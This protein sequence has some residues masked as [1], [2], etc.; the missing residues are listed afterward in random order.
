[1][2][3]ITKIFILGIISISSNLTAQ[4]EQT[5]IDLFVN[6]MLFLADGFASPASESAAYQAT[7]G[8]F[9]SAR[10][11]ETWKVDISVHANGIFVPSSK[12]EFTINNNDFNILQITGDDRAVIP[13][14]FGTETD[15]QFEG[16]VEY[17]GQTIPISGFDAIDGIDKGA[18]VYP[19]AQV[20]VGLPYGTEIGVRAL[21]AMEI[22]GSEFS[23]YGVGLKHNFSQYFRFNNEEDLQVAAV[24]A[25]N[26]FDVKYDF[27]PISVEQVVQLSQ[28]DV[29]ANVWM[30][31]VLASKRYENFEIFGALG[32]AQSDFEYEFG[33]S[34]VALPIINNE[35][36]RLNDKEAQFK[37]DIGFNLYFNKFKISTMA[38]AGKF[39][40]VNL[41]LHFLL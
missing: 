9:T 30:A 36:V 10:A 12:K 31:E 22:D 7:A 18:L 24:L 40:N 27:D 16:E 41:G 20:S 19:F 4:E 5:D 38:T 37:G 26:I 14:A 28:I 6:D 21:P 29:S 11:L 8:W 34:G 33:G 15:V 17:G 23:T 35:L 1:M 3:N 39:V 32:V 13:T 25:Y 2:K